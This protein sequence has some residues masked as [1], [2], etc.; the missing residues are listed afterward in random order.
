MVGWHGKQRWWDLERSPGNY[1][2]NYKAILQWI[3]GIDPRRSSAPHYATVK[4]VPI[5]GAAVVFRSA[6]NLIHNLPHALC[7]R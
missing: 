1:V 4:V 5:F 3:S 6:G 2:I 7:D